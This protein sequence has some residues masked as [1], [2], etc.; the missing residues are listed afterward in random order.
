MTHQAAVH[1]FQ[2]RSYQRFLCREVPKERAHANTGPLSYV[3]NGRAETHGGEYVLR[4][5]QQ[6]RTI[7][8]GVRPLGA[9]YAHLSPAIMVQA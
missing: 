5:V 7:A 1:R 2:D 6:T 3:L 9:L 4:R 8:Y